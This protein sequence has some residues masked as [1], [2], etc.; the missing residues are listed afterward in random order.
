MDALTP[1][2][3]RARGAALALASLVLPA[4][5]SPPPPPPAPPSTKVETLSPETSQKIDEALDYLNNNNIEERWRKQLI[6]C[7]SESELAKKAAIERTVDRIKRSYESKAS[8]PGLLKP[9]GRRRAF[10]ALDAFGGTDPD[11]LEAFKKGASE[12]DAGCLAAAAAALAGRGDESAFD[13]LMKAVRLAKEDASIQDRAA[14]AAL[15]LA[16]P[17]RLESV[18]KGVDAGSRK[19]LGPVALACLPKDDA[20]KADALRATARGHANPDARILALELLKQTGDAELLPIAREA[21]GASEATVRTAALKVLADR[22]GDE[23]AREL[24]QALAKDPADAAA[25]AALLARVDSSQA[26]EVACQ[27]VKDQGRAAATR[28][29]V[30]REVL[31]KLKDPAVP[32][33]LRTDA[34]REKGLAALRSAIDANDAAVGEAVVFALGRSGDESDAEPLSIRLGSWTG[35]RAEAA[36]RALGLIG[37]PRA[38]ADLIERHGKDSQL[39][40]ACR[41]ALVGMKDLGKVPGDQ[42]LALIRQLASEDV[43]IRK[44]AIVVLKALKGDSDIHDFD[45]EGTAPA[46]ERSIERWKKWWREKLVAR[47]G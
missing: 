38:S 24:G 16:K 41:E 34:A 45:P 6:D 35:P 42:G 33:S 12:S 21:A 19:A 46:R 47:G 7:A 10:E 4:C 36:V 40:N 23:A 30:A 8:G 9:P 17:E 28:V 29:A 3:R 44:S 31:A 39:R 11:A 14:S 5:G 37:G 22:P 27:V 25:V 18:W 15:K 20:A 26:I 2:P 43:A 32:G 1:H 13:T